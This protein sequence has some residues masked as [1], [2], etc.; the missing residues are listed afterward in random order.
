M[1]ERPAQKAGKALVWQVMQLGGDKLLFFIR[2]LVLARLLTPQDFGLVAI[3]T[4][5]MGF[6]QNITNIGLIPALVQG[7]EI[8]EKQYNSAWTAGMIRAA[9]I[10]IVMAVA[11]PLIAI[12]FDEPRATPIIRVFALY[13]LLAASIS[14][15]VAEQNR[16]LS[17][18]PLALL[19]LTESLVK[20]VVSVAL[21][22]VFGFWGLVIGTLA[23]VAAISI[24][25]YILAPHRPKL[26][27]D[28]ESIRP[29]IRFGQ[30]MFITSLIAMVGASILRIVITR[31]L[32]AA[33]LGLYYL[34]AQL[35]YIPSEVSSGVFGAVAFPM[36]SRLQADPERIKR[37]FQTMVVGTVALLYPAC[38]L[39]IVVAPTFV[40]EVLGSK[41]NGTETI[42]QILSFATMIGIFGDTVVEILKGMGRPDKRMMM[43]LMQTF[44]LIAFVSLLTIRFGIIGA[45]LASLPAVLISQIMGIVF[46]G[47]LM[48]RPFSG[49]GKSLTAVLIASLTGATVAFVLDK[50]LIGIIGLVAAGVGAALCTFAIL[51]IA[52]QKWSLGFVEDL[53]LIFPGITRYIRALDVK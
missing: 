49:L 22:V 17:F 32:G 27:L 29:L 10:A 1:M 33:A 16:N 28:W 23:G 47:Q 13:P 37:V 53:I 11:A 39:I 31:Q 6:F 35:A 4:T 12:I 14:I 15:K 44:V 40:A 51:W 34:A 18:R 30:W 43:G 9:L 25:S 21:A 5:A 45:A 41:W 42:I 46:V 26:I 52:N 36:F 3:G 2:I 7:K 24:F 20:A 19:K 48:P 8:T 50:Y 38:L